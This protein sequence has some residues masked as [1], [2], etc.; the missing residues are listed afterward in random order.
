MELPVALG[1][2]SFLDLVTVLVLHHQ[3]SYG[4]FKVS[5]IYELAGSRIQAMAPASQP[6]K[7]GAQPRSLALKVLRNSA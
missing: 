6:E 1:L 2:A 5:L 7:L 3:C 4:S